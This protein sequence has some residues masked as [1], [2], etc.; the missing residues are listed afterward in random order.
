MKNHIAV[1]LALFAAIWTGASAQGGAALTLV[2]TVTLPGY[3][4][5]FDHFA[6]DR[7]RG[8]ILVAAEDHATLEVFDLKTGNHL[9]TITGFG[10]PHSILVRPGSSNILVTDSGKE[11]TAVLDAETYAQE[12]IGTADAGR[13]FGGLR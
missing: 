12:G 13:R 7:Q 3:T 4:G 8:R 1:T 2:K 5:D 6:I 11:M 9:R 10:A